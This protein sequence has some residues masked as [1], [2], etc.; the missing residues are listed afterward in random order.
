MTTKTTHI[1]V[2]VTVEE[3]EKIKAYASKLAMSQSEF[4]LASIRF[5]MNE[6]DVDQKHLA[7]ATRLEAL[8]KRFSSLESS[9]THAA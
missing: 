8:E 3:L 2:R 6:N 9:L 1:T 5:A 4:A 7:L